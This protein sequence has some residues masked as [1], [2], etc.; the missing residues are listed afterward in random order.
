[1]AIITKP[2]VSKNVAAT[3]T[4]NKAELAAIPSVVAHPYFNNTTNWKFVRLL[5]QSSPGN[6]TSF[7]SF[8]ATQVTPQATFLVSAKARDSFQI[9]KITILDYDGGFHEVKR[10]ELNVA[11][12][13]ITF[14]AGP[15]ITG[16]NYTNGSYSLGNNIDFAVVFN[17]FDLFVSGSPLLNLTIG[18]T[19]RTASL[20][21]VTNFGVATFNFRYTVQAGDLDADGIVIES[22]NA[23]GAIFTNSIGGSVTPN[24]SFTPIST[25]IIIPS[26]SSSFTVGEIT[27]FT[28]IE[29]FYN[30]EELTGITY[31]PVLLVRGIH[32]STP[33]V[34][35]M[36]KITNSLTRTVAFE[37]PGGDN[38]QIA[39]TN[40]N[41]AASYREQSTGHPI[42]VFRGRPNTS[43]PNRKVYKWNSFTGVV[44]QLDST[45]ISGE[46]LPEAFFTTSWKNPG[47]PSDVRTIV[48]FSAINEFGYRKLFKYD[49]VTGD[50]FQIQDNHANAHDN[51]S[52]F[53]SFTH[54][55]GEI[56]TY[57]F[58][59]K[60]PN[61]FFKGEKILCR[62]S[63]TGTIEYISQATYVDPT[64]GTLDIIPTT[65]ERGLGSNALEPY[66]PDSSVSNTRPLSSMT[67]WQ[68]KLIYFAYYLGASS[69]Y[70]CL[71]Q[72]DGNGNLSAIGSTIPDLSISNYPTMVTIIGDR[73]SNPV[74]SNLYFSVNENPG[75]GEAH[76]LYRIGVLTPSLQFSYSSA[77]EIGSAPNRKGTSAGILYAI[78]NSTTLNRA[79]LV[80]YPEVLA[81]GPDW[82]IPNNQEGIYFAGQGKPL[83]MAEHDGY[84]YFPA[85]KV[86][87]GE[88]S[89]PGGVV[90]KLRR[91][92][93]TNTVPITSELVHD[94]NNETAALAQGY[95]RLTDMPYLLHS[96]LGKLFYSV[97]DTNF[98]RRLFYITHL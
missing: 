69:G 59:D 33:G 6:Q 40:W 96:S 17:T 24:L 19:A 58:I 98:N 13:D 86:A 71:A 1:M 41:R 56:F 77:A 3:F 89:P 81:V 11:D 61:A 92:A 83:T 65:Y 21:S 14:V 74:D 44:T 47:N 68:N 84:F 63:D 23:N 7:V 87:D 32:E 28:D 22:L 2:S 82:V 37:I 54:T 88:V 15:V 80:L 66:V 85:D 49:T 26:P 30:F 60:D 42:L 90:S 94:L 75:I 25:S 38:T 67:I 97:I 12:F 8:D 31:S 70:Q 16:I 51:P 48:L 73:Y 4:L 20:I 57:F 62:M 10:S 9:Q 43:A 34:T 45:N 72:V 53:I 29:E 76:T 93:L 55:S 78:G 35:K 95:P 79:A 36:Y 46:D 5:Y 91:V 18:S 52:D 50:V 64:Y 27:G 39:T